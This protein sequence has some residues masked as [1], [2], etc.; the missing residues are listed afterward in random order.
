MRNFDVALAL[1]AAALLL[2]PGVGR[3]EGEEEPVR[4]VTGSPLPMEQWHDAVDV[5]AGALK[6]ATWGD[7]RIEVTVKQGAPVRLHAFT[8]SKTGKLPER[9]KDPKAPTWVQDKRAVDEVKT[10]FSLSD[11]DCR[12]VEL[13]QGEIATQRILVIGVDANPSKKGAAVLWWRYSLPPKEKTEVFATWGVGD[14]KIIME[15]QWKAPDLKPRVVP[16]VSEKK[17]DMLL[18]LKKGKRIVAVLRY[19]APVPGG[20]PYERS[21]ISVDA[22]A[23]RAPGAA[24]LVPEPSSKALEKFMADHKPKEMDPRTA[25][26]LLTLDVKVWF[27]ISGK[28]IDGARTWEIYEKP[29]G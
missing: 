7:L 19:S 21:K 24:D 23:Q 15:D 8:V 14:A 13:G 5:P 29:G 16:C 10:W 6:Y 18:V 27:V 3:G 4:C 28:T 17:E 22:E 9:D 1:A 11:P 25:T 26:F 20:D 2:H 12:S